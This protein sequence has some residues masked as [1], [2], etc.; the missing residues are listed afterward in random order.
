[1]LE[2]KER[3]PQ[4]QKLMCVSYTT[5]GHIQHFPPGCAQFL[6]TYLC[7]KVINREMKSRKEASFYYGHIDVFCQRF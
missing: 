4:Q 6:L 3:K 7:L 2:R 5:T 1:M